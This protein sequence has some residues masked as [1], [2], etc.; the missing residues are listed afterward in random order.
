MT[1]TLGSPEVASR[2]G[3][4]P[5]PAGSTPGWL[6]GV[7][8]AAAVAAA[9]IAIAGAVTVSVRSHALASARDTSEPLVFYAQTV[10]VDLSDANT[11][12]AGGFLSPGGVPKDATAQFDADM[13]KASAALVAAIQK[14]GGSPLVTAPEQQLSAGMALYSDKVA[15]AEALYGQGQPVGAAYLAEANHFMSTSLLPS[16]LNIYRLEQQKLA[17]D[18]RRA[19]SGSGEA[20]VIGLAVLLLVV[21]AHLQFG[22]ARRFRRLLNP[23]ALLATAALA[24]IAVWMVVGLAAQGAAVSRAARAGSAPL[25]VLTEARILDGQA[26]ADDQLTLVTRDAVTS[27]QTDFGKVSARLRSLLGGSHGGWTPTESADLRLASARWGDY[28]TAHSQ[29]R[30]DDAADK[31][32]AAIGRDSQA[33]ADAAARLDAALAAGVAQAVSVFNSSARSA[34]DDVAGLLVGFLILMAV[35]AVGVVAGVQPRLKE[36]R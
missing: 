10:V 36:Y 27:Y 5:S 17:A 28:S 29:V 32:A 7:A 12:M 24:A 26:R 25:D 16:A 15:T 6:R 8:V 11:T 4:V 30:T 3:R 22:L 33:A 9:A 18:S 21:L 1:A 34:S 35:A 31:T 14:A 19:S 23:G 20:V 2:R 13:A